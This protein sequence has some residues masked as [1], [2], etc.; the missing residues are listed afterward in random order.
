[1]KNLGLKQAIVVRTDLNLSAGKLAVQ[2]AHASLS[3]ALIAK[4]KNR[5]WFKKW[6]DEGQ[7]KIVLKASDLKSLKELK[8]KADS[9][10]IPNNLIMDAGLTEIPPGTITCLGLGPAPE[11]KINKIV[12]SLPLL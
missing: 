7:K 1:M 3:S 11:E 6:H 2:V 8:R 10:K 4:S 12:G 5:S 9:L